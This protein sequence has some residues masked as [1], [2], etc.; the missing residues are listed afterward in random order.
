MAKQRTLDKDRLDRLLKIVALL[1]MAAGLIYII[2][3]IV[4]ILLI[5]F[6]GILLGVLINGTSDFLVKKTFLN[7]GAALT[8]V[9]VLLA[10]IPSG[11][12]W[13]TGDSIVAQ[14]D[15]LSEVIQKS[16]SDIKDYLQGKKW[17]RE[18]I[19]NFPG[20]DRL[21]DF[22][23]KQ[24]G[25][26]TGF[27]ASAMN[28][29]M[30]IVIIV[31]IAIFLSI[32]PRVYIDNFIILFPRRHRNSVSDLMKS[33]YTSLKMW[34]LGRII[35]MIV[36]GILTLIGYLI[37]GLPLALLLAII[38]AVLSF[39]PN[40]GPILSLLSALP[41]A[42]IQGPDKILYVIIV[43]FAVQT[44]E[45]YVI[46][47]MVQERAVSLPPALLFSAQILLGLVGGGYGLAL[48]TPLLVAAIVVI[49]VLYVQNVLGEK[50]K[51]LGH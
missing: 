17:G 5:I 28:F 37:I 20:I 46:T 24:L 50:I 49:Q 19:D 42:F 33:L 48:A 2:N 31:L 40:I 1:L 43:Y 21:M 47:P 6:T 32:N 10:L 3:P 29:A 4:Q 7:R 8:V 41:V 16:I 26:I 38:A 13:L 45:S 22:G 15:K 9:I 12:L 44:L 39:I 14:V 36:V 27:L 34:L 30:H 18:V 35:S 25:N 11:I 51:P 23:S